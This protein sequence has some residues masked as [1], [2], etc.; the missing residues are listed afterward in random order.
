[1]LC[2]LAKVGS[3]VIGRC[4]S[5]IIESLRKSDLK[6]EMTLWWGEEDYLVEGRCSIIISDFQVKSYFKSHRPERFLFRLLE[7]V[8]MRCI[9]GSLP[10]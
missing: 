3:N 2:D 9:E 4:L 1:M 8:R 7:D 6:Y 5:I 10:G